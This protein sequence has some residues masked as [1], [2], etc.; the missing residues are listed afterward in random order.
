[1][2]FVSRIS[3]NRHHE[4]KNE[5]VHGECREYE[6]DQSGHEE[7]QELVGLEKE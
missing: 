5:D 4:K 1:M 2:I 6:L 3:S 7:D